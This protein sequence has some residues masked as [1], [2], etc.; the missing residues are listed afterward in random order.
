MKHTARNQAP[1]VVKLSE[2]A[3]DAPTAVVAAERQAILCFTTFAAIG[4]DHH[5]PLPFGEEDSGQNVFHPIAFGLGSIVNGIGERETFI[6]G[7][8]DDLRSLAAARMADGRPHFLRLR[9]CIDDRFPPVQLALLMQLPRQ[10]SQCLPKFP[11]PHPLLKS[12]VACLAGRIPV[13][14]FP[15]PR[16]AP[17]I[18]APPRPKRRR[19]Y[20]LLL[21]T[22]IPDSPPILWGKLP[23]PLQIRTLS[24]TLVLMRLLLI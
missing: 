22:W 15:P 10:R 20:L 23:E 13:R 1:R 5:D 2:V 6:R 11:A 3:L 7:D 18:H 4:R 24:R 16:S 14:R 19:H 17:H 12:P 8:S 9:N 21:A